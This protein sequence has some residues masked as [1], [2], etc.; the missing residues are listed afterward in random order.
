MNYGLPELLEWPVEQR[1]EFR[2]GKRVKKLLVLTVLDFDPCVVCKMLGC[3]L[4]RLGGRALYLEVSASAQRLLLPVSALSLRSRRRCVPARKRVSA[5]VCAL[6]FVKAAPILS[7]LLFGTRCGSSFSHGSEDGVRWDD[8][9]NGG[10]I[11]SRSIL[12][13]L[14]TTL[15]RKL[16]PKRKVG[17][18]AACK[19]TPLHGG[20]HDGVSCMS[21]TQIKFLSLGGEMWAAVDSAVSQYCNVLLSQRSRSAELR[22]AEPR[23]AGTNINPKSTPK[24]KLESKLFIH[25]SS[26]VRRALVEGAELWTYLLQQLLGAGTRQRDA[27]FKGF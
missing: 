16:A 25:S 27:K 1:R 23:A 18:K 11:Y 7:F 14:C 24:S 6:C 2:V 15:C 17:S 22:A 8:V 5:H 4:L 9:H 13:A 21:E 12:H 26:S 3:A 20:S 19:S 10:T